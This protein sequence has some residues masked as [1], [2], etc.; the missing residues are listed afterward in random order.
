MDPVEPGLACGSDTAHLSLFGYDPRVHY[1][2]RGAFE[3]MGAGLDMAPGDIAFKCNFATLDP[4]TGVVLRRRADRRFE[5][6]GPVLCAALDGLRLPSFPQ[7]GVSVKYA[8]EHR[9]GVVE[10]RPLDASAEAAHTAAVVNELSVAMR[11]ILETHPINAA[12]AAVGQP[13]ANVVL[14]RGCGSR[15]AVQSFPDRHDGLRACMVAPTKIIAGLGMSLGIDVL[16]VPGT[17]GDYRTL[18]HRKAEAIAR[19]LQPQPRSHIASPR[20]RAPSHPPPTCAKEGY[21]FGFLHVK[22]VDDTGHDRLVGIKVRYLEVVDAMVGQLLRLLVAAEASSSTRFSIVVTGDHSTPVEFGDHSHEPVPVA[23]AHVRHVVKC[24]GGSE[25]VG[26]IPLG[27]IPHPSSEE[28]ER[29][30]AAAAANT[31]SSSAQQQS[32]PADPGGSRRLHGLTFGDSVAAFSELDAAEGALGRFPGSQLMT[33]IKEF[34]WPAPP[35]SSAGKGIQSH[36]VHGYV[37]NKAAVLPLQLLNFEFSN[38][39]GYPSWKGTV[40]SGEQLLEVLDGYI[41]SVSLLRAIVQVA[42]RLRRY[43]PGLV[44]VC[45]PVMGDEGRLY[46]RPEMPEAFRTDIIPLASVLTPNQFE[47][48]L[49]TGLRIASEAE[50]LAACAALHARGPHTVVITSSDLPGHASSVTVVAST[51]RAQEAGAPQRLRL[52]VPRLQAYFTGTGDLLSALLLGWM[53]RHPANLKLA[54]ELAVAGLQGVLRDTA[55][56]AA[57]MLAAGSSGCGGQPPPAA[58]ARAREL[59]L[60]P[61]Q[62]LL[63]A[64]VIELRAEAL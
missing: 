4:A 1:R 52:R 54:V 48:E 47:A 6:L 39:T 26:R 17:T 51:T 61:N 7:H 13:P 31:S 5:E 32:E 55:A 62:H 35:S 23:I 2:G 10:A 33:L 43:N 44:Y 22:A 3:S 14:L 49:L 8:T 34:I 15:I 46:C 25:A 58:L 20:H 41:G 19:A 59:R 38:N 56:H 64:P 18:F 29:V 36:V 57:D 9:C 21:D 11:S 40:M 27:E 42:E 63:A 28:S 16:D 50:A 60:V 12:R 24:L 53:S 45:D 37:G 30:L